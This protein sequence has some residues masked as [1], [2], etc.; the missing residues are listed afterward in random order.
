MKDLDL[1]FDKYEFN[2]KIDIQNSVNLLLTD[3]ENGLL[4]DKKKNSAMDMIPVWQNM[5]KETPKN[6]SVIVI[7][8]GGTNFRAAL[9]QFDKH[10]QPFV[11][12]FSKSFMPAIDEEMTNDE[13]F[14]AISLKL[15][16]LKN[17]SSIIAFCFSFAVEIFPDGSG[18]ALKLS[19]EIKLPEIT[20][21][22]I[23]EGL[24][25]AL[26]RRGWQNDVKVV[27]TNDTS[28]VLQSGLFYNGKK[29]NSYIGFVLGTGLNCAYIE[30]NSIEKIKNSSFYGQPQ[31]V[32]CEAGKTS[33]IKQ[34]LFDKRLTDN[35][36]LTDDYL[37]ERMCSGKYLGSLTSLIIRTA[38]HDKLFSN[39]NIN[40]ALSHFKDAD[41]QEISHFLKECNHKQNMFS[42][43]FNSNEL[44]EDYIKLYGICNSVFERAA[45][46][47]ASVIAAACLK[48]SC[49]KQSDICITADGSL[50]IKGFMLK[51]KVYEYL[52]S[53]L[54]EKYGIKFI[55]RTED[56]SV[57]LGS[58]VSAL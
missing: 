56:D 2:Y 15:E 22:K 40:D 38:A 55:I 39:T 19:K 48:T 3:M 28:A 13:F 51:E 47:S 46:L 52:Y 58:A 41:T 35:F 21:C 7:D 33:V 34:S 16:Y 6:K 8:A 49:K 14:D 42:D 9:I 37:L 4:C 17:R 54:T 20:N 50:F 27:M 43:F 25:E 29:F 31:I 32:V 23:N 44:S 18:K 11:D 30:F 57:L 53:F 36:N 45:R 26:L 24:K 5:F 1:F 12:L 10:G